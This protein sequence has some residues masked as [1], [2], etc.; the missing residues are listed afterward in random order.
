MVA[1]CLCDSV[2]GSIMRTGNTAVSPV[3]LPDE[4][5]PRLIQDNHGD[6]MVF[7]KEPPDR[8]VAR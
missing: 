5:P 1:L 4:R 7:P 8:P 3:S 6:G 2:V